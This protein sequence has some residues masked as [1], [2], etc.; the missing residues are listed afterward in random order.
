MK[1]TSLQLIRSVC[2]AAVLGLI[3]YA[4]NA[5][6]APDAAGHPMKVKPMKAHVTILP[7]SDPGTPPY[8]H[9]VFRG[10]GR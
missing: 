9:G 8:S 1:T 7:G 10:F 3:T 5:Q 4:V 2:V 6:A